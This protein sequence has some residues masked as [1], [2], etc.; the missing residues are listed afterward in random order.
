M[1]KRVHPFCAQS[2]LARIN[3]VRMDDKRQTM[4]LNVM[5]LPRFSSWSGYVNKAEETSKEEATW[6]SF[7]FFFFFGVNLNLKLE[8]IEIGKV[9]EELEFFWIICDRDWDFYPFFVIKGVFLIPALQEVQYF[10]II[11]YKS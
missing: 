9:L 1:K 5:I 6:S 8:L 11:K 2:N 7:Y 3:F 4:M 10:H